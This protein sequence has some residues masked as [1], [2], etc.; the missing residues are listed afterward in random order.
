MKLFLHVAASLAAF[1]LYFSPARGQHSDAIRM[2]QVGFYP[3]APKVAVVAANA[4]EAFE[5]KD[6]KSGKNGFKRE[7]GCCAYQP[8]FGQAYPPC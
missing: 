8:A 7:A 3:S 2:N 1:G 4:A 5:V 6:A